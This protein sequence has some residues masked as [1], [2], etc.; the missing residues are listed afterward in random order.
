MTEETKPFTVSDRR[1]FTAEGSV[2]DETPP[3]T[4]EEGK[5]SQQKAESPG[6]TAGKDAPV[7]F[8]TFLLSLGAQA[9]GLL[10]G[11]GETE[12]R[13]RLLREARSFISIIEM[14]KEK[15]EGRRTE[16]EDRVVQALLYELRMT[17]VSAVR[18][19]GA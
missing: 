17:Y 6:G 8:S 11:V 12:D 18:V 15:T 16:D 10:A 13:Q 2:R 14:L 7:E 1:H 19:D 3:Q 5:G 9:A 4:A